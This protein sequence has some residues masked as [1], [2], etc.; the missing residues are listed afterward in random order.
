[1]DLQ[2]WCVKH[3]C[4][5]SVFSSKSTS[6]EDKM[7]WI[8]IA[9]WRHVSAVKE[10]VQI[11]QMWEMFKITWN[12]ARL[13]NPRLPGNRPVDNTNRPWFP[14]QANKRQKRRKCFPKWW[15]PEGPC[16]GL[17]L[18]GNALWPLKK[19]VKSYQGNSWALCWAKCGI[20]FLLWSLFHPVSCVFADVK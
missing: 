4:V 3:L 13:R 15:A 8:L 9:A 17:S 11:I 12:A 14:R 2:S 6:T 7:D 18:C 10:A 19:S 16:G 20:L 5:I 1:M